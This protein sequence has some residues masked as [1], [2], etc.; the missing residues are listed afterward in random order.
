M[1]NK[2]Y[3]KVLWIDKTAEKEEI[4][5]AYRR[6]AMKYHPDRNSWNKDAETKFKEIN[7]AYSILSDSSKRQQYDTFGSVWWGNP[8]WWWSSWW[9]N[10][11]VDLWDIFESFF[12]WGSSW[13]NRKR[14]TV[15]KW[16]DLEY[17]IDIDLKTS[18]YGWKETIK[19]KKLESCKTCLWEWW[20]SKKTCWKCNW[21][22]QVVFTQNS[23]FWVIQQTKTCNNCWGSGEEFEKIC[24]DCNWRKRVETENK[25]DVDIPAWIDNGMIIKMTWEWN[26]WIWTKTL[27]DLYMKFKVSLEEKWL[28]RDWTDLHYNLE[29]SIIEA[30]LWTK[31]EI[32]IPII[33]KRNISIKSWTQLWSTIKV[34][35]DWVKYIDND[36]KWDLFIELDIKIPKKL[37]K[38]ERELYEEIAKEKKINVNNKKWVFESF[39][40]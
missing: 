2:D 37:S 16:E 9:F 19:Y 23:V 6:K 35:W 38:K 12:W 8:F 31:K 25:I 1:A 33:W 24:D 11:D 4:K 20:S 5:R 22:G 14:W 10:M 17:H 7:E 40:W 21:S 18:I 3:Y 36:K 29:I 27:W 15:Q 28:K 39:F 32:S 30:I 26:E 13:W 34:H